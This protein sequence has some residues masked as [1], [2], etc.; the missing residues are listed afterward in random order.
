M[1]VHNSLGFHATSVIA[2]A[3][4]QHRS[5]HHT[6]HANELDTNKVMRQ[7]ELHRAAHREQT[8]QAVFVTGRSW[9]NFAP[10]ATAGI[11]PTAA[12]WTNSPPPHLSRHWDD[13]ITGMITSTN[14]TAKLLIAHFLCATRHCR[15]LSIVRHPKRE[16]VA[17]IRGSQARGVSLVQRAPGPNAPTSY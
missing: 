6:K 1:L 11:P 8:A 10:S 17:S 7:V 5:S 13:H 15:A 4:A 3:W 14:K 9:K 2:S 12:I 16:E